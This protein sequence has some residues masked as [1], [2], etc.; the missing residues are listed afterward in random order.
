MPSLHPQGLEQEG[1][2]VGPYL[3][4]LVSFSFTAYFPEALWVKSTTQVSED[5]RFKNEQ[6]LFIFSIIFLI[7]VQPPIG[8]T[9]F[10]LSLATV[11]PF[12]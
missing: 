2:V 6:E 5:Q 8:L 4:L 11:D 3:V 12:A 10:S 9:R 7:H 1:Q